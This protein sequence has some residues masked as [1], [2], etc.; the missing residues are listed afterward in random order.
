MQVVLSFG[1]NKNGTL[2]SFKKALVFLH[3]RVGEVVLKSSVITTPAWGFEEKTN[4]FLN[5]IIVIETTIAPKELLKVTQKI[6]IELGRNPKL[7]ENKYEDRVIDIDIL[8]YENL[9][10][11]TTKL[12]VPHKFVKE[13]RFI[14]EPMSEILPNFIHPVFN[15]TI[16][17]L[18][19]ELA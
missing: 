7:F 9:I 18:L 17:E 2:D 14:L 19:A 11:K 8:F 12:T 15:K 4:D 16:Q 10:L 5:Q 6:E 1:G 13:R 3:E